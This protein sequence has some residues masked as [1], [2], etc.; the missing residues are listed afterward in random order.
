MDLKNSLREPLIKPTNDLFIASLL[1][2]PKNKQI[3]L[4]AINSVLNNFRQPSIVEATVLNPFN[5]L[6]YPVDKQIRLDVRV[7][8]EHDAFYNIEIQS[9]WHT[10]FFDR[11]LYYWSESY[12]SQLERGDEYTVL[13][14]VKSIIITEFPVFSSLKDLHTVFELRARENPNVILTDHLQIHFLRL[15][16][17]KNNLAG[18]NVICPGLRSWM[19]FLAFGSIYGEDKMSTLLQDSPQVREAYEELKLFSADPAMREKARERQRFITDM[20]LNINEA[21]LEGR[22]EGIAEER[23]KADAEKR[24]EKLETARKFKR[25]G[26]S[27]AMI[28]EATGLSLEEIERLN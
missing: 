14:P 12:E 11:V 21:R 26:A 5:I 1:S 7:K 19:N 25:L 18:L 20:R 28:A 10:G 15:G 4:S 2:S 17:I 8:D 23:A 27:A 24:A 22:N 13:C 3:L 16:N 6:D 9:E